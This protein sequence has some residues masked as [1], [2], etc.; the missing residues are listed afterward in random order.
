MKKIIGLILGVICV[1]S[2]AFFYFSQK[3]DKISLE[4]SQ[5]EITKIS[6]DE[7][8]NSVLSNPDKV[9]IYNIPN[10]DIFLQR[11]DNVSDYITVSPDLRGKWI[12]ENDKPDFLK[13]VFTPE[14]DWLADKKYKVSINKKIFKNPKKI[15]NLNLSF[16]T[17][18]NNVNIE[19]FSLWHSE[20]DLSLFG[21]KAVLKFD[22]PVEEPEIVLSY[23]KKEVKPKITFDQYKRYCFINYEPIQ[24]LDTKQTAELKVLDK[25]KELVIPEMSEFFKLNEIT[26]DI[27]GK[28]ENAA[29]AIIMEFSDFVS[30]EEVEKNVEVYLLPGNINWNEKTLKYAED[31]LKKS[32]KITVKAMPQDAAGTI[33]ALKYNKPLYNRYLYIKLKN[34]VKSKSNYN[35]KETKAYIEP[36]KNYETELKFIGYGNVL[37]ASGDKNLTIYSRLLDS[38]EVTVSRIFPDRLNLFVSQNF[39]RTNSFYGYYNNDDYASDY[40]YYYDPG[41][42]DKDIAEVFT[43]RIRLVSSPNVNY[44]SI[45]L[46]KY[47]NNGKLG[48]FNVEIYGNGIKRKKFILISDI[49]IIYKKDVD[50]RIKVFCVSVSS[51]LPLDGARVCLLARNGTELVVKN[52]DSNGTCEFEDIS[53]F[54]NEKD[55]EA[56]VVRGNNDVA[57]I[58]IDRGA[59]DIVYSKYDTSGRSVRDMRYKQADSYIFTDRGIY[60]PGEKVKFSVIL[61]NENKTALKGFP[62]KIEIEDC[63]GRTVFNKTVSSSSDGFN[64][65]EFQSQTTLKTGTYRINVYNASSKRGDYYSKFLSSCE[66]K[67]EEFKEDKL[68][69]QTSIE[70]GS[71]K[72]WQSFEGLSGKVNLQ[73]LYGIPAQGNEVKASVSLYPYKFHF[74]EY[75]DFTFS[76]ISLDNKVKIKPVQD[77]LETKKTSSTGEVSY[78]LSFSKYEAGTYRLLFSAEGFERESGSSVKSASQQL[79]SPN[80][81][82]V[83]YKTLSDLNFIDKNAKAVIKF[84]AVDNDLKKIS[85]NKLK[86]KT[87]NLQ[88][89]SVPVKEYNGRYKYHSVKQEKEVSSKNF[90][91]SENSTDFSIDTSVS[92]NYKIEIVDENGTILLSMEYV[93]AGNSNL[94]SQLEKN[95]ELFINLRNDIVKR[96]GELEFNVTA[97]FTGVGLITIEKDKVYAYK[98]FNMDTNSKLC[99]ITV[100]ENI[101]D[102]AYLNVSVLKAKNSKEVFLNPHSYALKYFKIASDTKKEV[103]PKITVPELVKPGSELKIEYSTSEPARIILYGVDEGILQVAKYKTPDPL[104]YFFRKP[105]LDVTSYQTLDLFLPEFSVIKEVY[106][107]GGGTGFDSE[108]EALLNAGLNPFKRQSLAPVVFWSGIIDSDKT[109]KKYTYNVPDYFN[110]RLKIMCVAVGKKTSFGSSEKSVI[111]RAPI[112][113]SAGAPVVAAPSDIFDVTLKITNSKEDSKAGDF[114]AVISVSDNLEVSGEKTKTVHVEYGKE[115]TLTFKVKV[116][117]KLGNA[118]IKFNVTDKLSDGKAKITSAL[119]IRPASVYATDVTVGGSKTE[120]FEVK[121]FTN[122]DTYNEFSDKNIVVSNSPLVVAFGL[123]KYLEKFPHGCTEQITSQTYSSIALYGLTEENRTIFK[124]Y[125]E[126]LAPRQRVDGGFSPWPDYEGVSDYASLYVLQFLTDAQSLGYEVPNVML[127]KLLDWARNFIKEP[128]DKYEADMQAEALYLLA[129]NAIVLTG[130]ISKL[131]D[132]FDNNVKNWAGTISGAYIASTYRLLQNEDKA[133]DIIKKFKV[134]A[135]KNDNQVYSDYDSDFVRNLTYVYLVS[136]HFPEMLNNPEI[137]KIIQ[138]AMDNIVNKN[139]NT[140]S[141][142]KTVLAVAAYSTANKDKDD[143]IEIFIDGQKTERTQNKLGFMQAAIPAKAKNISVKSNTTGSLGLFYAITQQGFFKDKKQNISKGLQIDKKYFDKDGNETNLVR[144]GDEIKVKITIKTTDKKYVSNMVV[145][146]LLPGGLSIVPGSLNGTFDS[147]DIREDRLLIYTSVGS[148]PKEFSYEA[149]AVAS[150]SFVLPAVEACHLYDLNRYAVS[151]ESVFKVNPR[152]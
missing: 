108:A 143:N 44:S 67:I 133:Q 127:K 37:A 47:I 12:L 94:G 70:G 103:K 84:I 146:D 98:W 138:N 36:I 60:K 19:D 9:Y 99:K 3:S 141:S 54:V 8:N 62:I 106:G 93:I 48:L 34:T 30:A 152:K 86:L 10:D 116:L 31:S 111:V 147:F 39:Y 20:K 24:L 42:Q 96:G 80:K 83:G 102:G 7:D 151:S 112:V 41:I 131:E 88:Y 72:G 78:D 139:Y 69:I 135:E 17:K 120:N 25:K 61:M 18:P 58:P 75:K 140:L 35:L 29:Q 11:G 16:S 33:V 117:D 40:G 95:S 50:N 28:D 49:G 90:A 59:R 5:P 136:K 65:S 74:E 26:T 122:I 107:I 22:F 2:F 129:R 85:L 77:N 134:K 73:N 100:P 105:A 126:K 53:A 27:V 66:F 148:E 32:E 145:T 64:E 114:E 71:H 110:G 121:N 56:I 51:G 43:E 76:D 52:T 142:A 150:G 149:K 130:Q 15:K 123:E 87:Y 38:V 79:I 144:V 63:D 81:Y 14:K 125:I 57:F 68:K 55:P 101:D 119:S 89:V 23:N 132:Y 91:I 46:S 104:S 109:P 45:D 137:A 115:D 124:R 128:N 21:I 92:G 97:P 6:L 4:I 13:I 1:S 118:E 113:L 82:I